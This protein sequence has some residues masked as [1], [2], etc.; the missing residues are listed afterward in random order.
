[1]K[2]LIVQSSGHDYRKNTEALRSVGLEINRDYA[3][4]RYGYEVEEYLTPGEEQVL[5]IGT[6]HGNYQGSARTI[7]ELK[8]KNPQLKAW[9]FS[10]LSPPENWS[11][12]YE[13]T[14]GG[15]AEDLNRCQKMADEVRNYLG[16]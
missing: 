14:I 8:K 9:F 7:H 13:K 12:L 16:R 2:I 6:V 3:Y 10:V 15:G 11:S 1:M 5:I 4:G